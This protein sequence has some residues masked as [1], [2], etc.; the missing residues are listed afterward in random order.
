[1]LFKSQPFNYVIYD[2]AHQLK[3]MDTLKYQ[4]LMRVRQ[5]MSETVDETVGGEF[6]GRTYTERQVSQIWGGPKKS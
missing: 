2:E 1:M 6:D 5:S 3:N 4:H